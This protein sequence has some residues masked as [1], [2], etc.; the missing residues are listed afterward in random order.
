MKVVIGLEDFKRA[1]EGSKQIGKWES[2]YENYY[3]QY[4]TIFDNQLK[5]LYM[6]DITLFKNFVEELDFKKTIAEVE[7]LIRSG[8][9][10]II[11]NQ[12]ERAHNNLEYSNEYNVYLLV[13]FGHIDGTA[14]VG[15]K[16]YVYYGLETLGKA[17]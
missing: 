17:Y 11:S 8:I 10:S 5:Y 13:G 7:T 2:W 15:D 9:V 1:F 12:L 14:F 3:L 16:P 4:K 6:E